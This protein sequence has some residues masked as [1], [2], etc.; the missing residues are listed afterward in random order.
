MC[1]FS[2]KP[3]KTVC[4]FVNVICN[5]ITQDF[6]WL[7]W[8][9]F[10]PSLAFIKSSWL[11]DDIVEPSGGPR[12]QQWSWDWGVAPTIL[13]EAWFGYPDVHCL[14]QSSFKLPILHCQYLNLVQTH[15][16]VGPIHVY[17]L[18]HL[19]T[20]TTLSPMFQEMSLDRS[21]SPTYVAWQSSHV[22][23]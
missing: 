12:H 17:M 20:H 6:V 14:R 22:M 9:V 3:G 18:W 19:T 21:V 23:W 5:L 7:T 1:Q 10:Q 11:H 8:Q 15:S 13:V 16:M 4:T 2:W